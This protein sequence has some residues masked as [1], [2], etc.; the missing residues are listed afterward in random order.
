MKI[1]QVGHKRIVYIDGKTV[2]FGD[3]VSEQHIRLMVPFIAK[4]LKTK[5]VTT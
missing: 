1:E 5:K 4:K 3:S 2:T